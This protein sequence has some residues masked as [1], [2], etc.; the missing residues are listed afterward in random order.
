M[1]PSLTPAPLLRRTFLASLA[2]PLAWAGTAIAPD[3]DGMMIIGGKRRFVLGLYDLPKVPQPWKEAGAAGFDLIHARASTQDFV[4][5]REAGLHTWVTVGSITEQNRA[6]DEQRIRS[7]V[8]QFRGEPALWFWETEDE[9][10]YVWKSPAPRV[11]PRQIVD[12]H[13]F[14]KALDPAHPLYLNHAPAN[15]EGTLRQYNA[16][17]EIIATDIYPVIPPGIRQEYALWPDGQHG[18]L[19]NSTI[20]QVGPYT[21]KMRRVAGPSRAVFIVLQAFAW[22]DLRQQERDPRMVLY[23]DGAQLRSMTYQAII[24]GANGLLFWGLANLGPGECAGR[25]DDMERSARDGGRTGPTGS[26]TRHQ[27][28]S[29]AAANPISRHGPQSRPRH[30]MDSPPVGG[31][32]ALAVR[33]RR[34]QPGACRL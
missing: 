21:D 2:A 10:A 13:D 31:G 19:L 23:P 25:R 24:H 14:V 15:L 6:A 18:D 27:P 28:C 7:V 1:T 4:H 32:R 17:A 3:H 20:S 8:E 29:S 9:P 33:K 12:T 16:G 26:A 5:A 34:S 11:S 30:R 22:E